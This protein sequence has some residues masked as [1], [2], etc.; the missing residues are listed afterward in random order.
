MVVL[1]LVRLGEEHNGLLGRHCSDRLLRLALVLNLEH[2]LLVEH[3]L[4]HAAA[5]GGAHGGN[6]RAA[7]TP[8]A[9]SRRAHLPR[10]ALDLIESQQTL[11]PSV[12]PQLLPECLQALSKGGVRGSPA[13]LKAGCVEAALSLKE[14]V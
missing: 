5:I 1:M 4:Q 9:G 13:L 12:L 2:P 6:Q 14:S 11:G 3:L 8:G 10:Q 7:A